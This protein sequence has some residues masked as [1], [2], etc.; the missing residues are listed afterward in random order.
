[1]VAGQAEEIKRVLAEL[2]KNLKN[3]DARGKILPWETTTRS[4]KGI[5]AKEI[6]LLS[7]TMGK[8][9]LDVQAYIRDFGSKQMN[10]RIGLRVATDMSLREFLD[11]WNG[12]KPKSDPTWI[13]TQQS[14]MQKS[15][16]F[17]AVGFLQGS[18]EKKDATT[19][20]AIIS[21]ELGV[22]AEVSWQYGWAAVIYASLCFVDFQQ[23]TTNRLKKRATAS[24]KLLWRTR[25]THKIGK[26]TN[27]ITHNIW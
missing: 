10:H 22:A 1:L 17:L 3:V 2:T 18:S 9:Y 15:S 4:K 25:N 14:E 27:T 6:P 19:I 12:L 23:F 20:N 26:K 13:T 16:K 11:T 7:P 5:G 21:A 8:K 24:K